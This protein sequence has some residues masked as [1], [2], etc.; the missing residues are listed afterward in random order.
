[1]MSQKVSWASKKEE[2]DFSTQK[3][4]YQKNEEAHRDFTQDR[5]KANRN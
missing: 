4:N 1:M 3:G 5:N 2:T